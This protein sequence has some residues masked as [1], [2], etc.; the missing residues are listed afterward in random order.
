MNIR[1]ATETDF[2]QRLLLWKGYQ[3]FYK[4]DIADT[5]TETTWSQF[6]DVAEPMY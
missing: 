3:V 4:A 1:M 6:H 5:I 2:S